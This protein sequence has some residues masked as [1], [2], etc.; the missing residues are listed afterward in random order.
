MALRIMGSKQTEHHGKDRLSAIKSSAETSGANR[1]CRAF[2]ERNG[3]E[4]SRDDDAEYDVW[5][6]RVSALVHDKT[7]HPLPCHRFDAKSRMRAQTTASLFCAGIVFDEDDVVT[8][9]ARIVPSMDGSEVQRVCRGEA[10]EGAC[11][12]DTLDRPANGSRSVWLAGL[13]G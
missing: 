2:L 9:A 7:L 8:Q 4:A 10:L 13:N 6:A 11:G 3:G 5:P 12:P 1:S